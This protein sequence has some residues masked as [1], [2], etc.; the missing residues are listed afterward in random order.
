VI[1]FIVA[2]KK[3]QEKR[4]KTRTKRKE[5]YELILA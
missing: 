2:L 4:L 3:K 5:K 1:I